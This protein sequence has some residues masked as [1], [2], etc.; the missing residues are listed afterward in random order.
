MKAAQIGEAVLGHDHV[1]VVLGLID[2]AAIGTIA[3][4][5]PRLAVDGVRKKL[6]NALPSRPP[7]PP[8]PFMIA[9]PMTSVEFT[10]P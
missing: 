4:I 9:L 5:A 8:M 2:V 7:L 6:R 1:H 10:L 3:E